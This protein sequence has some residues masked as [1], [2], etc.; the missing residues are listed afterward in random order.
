MKY[1]LPVILLKSLVLLPYQEVRLELNNEISK[2]TIAVS[3][4]YHDN[5]ILVICPLNQFE[6]HPDVSD[7]P[8]IGVV[9]KIKTKIELPNGN[10]RIVIRG[11]E[12]VD[13]VKYVN[14]SNEIDVLEALFESI[15]L[16]KYDPTAETAILRKLFSILEEYIDMNS[17]VSNSILSSLKG[18]TD[19]EKITDIITAF[20]PFSVTKKLEYM[21]EVNAIKRAQNLIEDLNIEIEII[22]LDQEIDN[23]LKSQFIE[24]EREIILKEKI[25]LL[26]QELGN[27]HT[28]EEEIISLY[29]K[30]EQLDLNIKTKKKIITEIKRYE[31]MSDNS[32][33][34][35]VVKNYIDW[36][37]SLPWQISSKDPDD[38]QKIK[39]TLDKN[40]YGLS[41]VKNTII[42]YIAARKINNQ[43]NAPIICLVGPPGVGKTTLAMSIAESLERE[44]YKISV[45]GL[46]DSNEL[47]GHR[48][49]Y[50]GAMPGKIIQGISKCNTNNP[51]F[52]IDEVDKMVKDFKGDPASSLLDILDVNLNKTFTDNYLE[53]PFD[54]SKVIFIL[55]A[56][57]EDDIPEHLKD[58][59][60]LI[61]LNSYSEY[62]KKDIAKKHLIPEILKTHKVEKQIKFSESAITNIIKNHT[63]EAGLRNLYRKITQVVRKVIV[64]N[65][66]ALNTLKITIKASDLNKYLGP[67]LTNEVKLFKPTIGT[68]NALAKTR[69]GGAITILEGIITEGDGR[70][71]VTGYVGRIMEE[72]VDVAKGYILNN[73][74]KF[75]IPKERIEKN[76]IYLHAIEGSIRK[77]GPSAGI[78]ITTSMLSLYKGQKIP[79]NIAF[80]GEMTLS[81]N[82]LEVGGV[83]EKIIGAFSRGIDTFIIPAVN[84]KDLENIQKK[85]LDKIKI[86]YVVHYDEVYKILFD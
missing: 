57:Y 36:I 69:I 47:L 15:E 51:L 61:Y 8:K 73:Y 58:R 11:I 42:E 2:K 54:L 67:D 9:G 76:D 14:Y 59:L 70:N 56:N 85:V 62:E 4:K 44:F 41:D 19:L 20:L 13:I 71:K 12:R 6:E 48:R 60:E 43:I 84:K 25:K 37:L 7:L 10:L 64:E 18:L 23:N 30:L 49:T 75:K 68:V 24:Q 86:H 16:V 50:L 77:D 40:H 32:P 80:T 34:I 55:T 72:S 63:S 82:I 26:N 29:D 22:K 17:T 81:G 5:E 52:L 28:K 78:A 65:F 3:N 46:N 45:G 31:I 1:N 33:E 38:L 74:K 27:Q 39:A 53:E 79:K 21:D 66:D 35:S 83:E